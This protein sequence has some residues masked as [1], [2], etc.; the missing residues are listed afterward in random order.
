MKVLQFALA[1]SL[2]ATPVVLSQTAPTAP[3]PLVVIDDA[4]VFADMAVSS[5]LYGVAASETA[6]ERTQDDTVR[7]FAEKVL[8][9]RRHAAERL[10]AAAKS[11]SLAVGE[12]MSPRHAAEAETLRSAEAGM[13]DA[14]YLAGQRRAIEE[15]VT[16]YQG[17]ATA[18]QAGALRDAAGELLPDIMAGQEEARALS[19]P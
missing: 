1:A 4:Q 8:S 7:A 18:G 9:E 2:L 15:E 19:S 11:D 16:L 17:F 12:R 13:F 14:L 6:L 3:P 10:M 5:A